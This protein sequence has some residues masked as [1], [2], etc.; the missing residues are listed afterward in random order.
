[1][2][3]KTKLITS[4]ADHFYLFLKYLKTEYSLFNENMMLLF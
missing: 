3:G 4:L 1:M 2:V